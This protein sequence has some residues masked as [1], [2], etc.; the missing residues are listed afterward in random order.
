M[1]VNARQAR[2]VD[3]RIFAGNRRPRCSHQNSF[4]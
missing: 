2:S 3:L 1:S 4:G